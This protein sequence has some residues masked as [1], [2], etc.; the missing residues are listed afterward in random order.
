[1]EQERILSVTPFSSHILGVFDDRV[2]LEECD[3][4]QEGDAIPVV[5]QV[6]KN[7]W[8]E[9][10]DLWL[11][12]KAEYCKQWNEFCGVFGNFYVRKYKEV[13]TI[14][15]RGD[16]NEEKEIYEFI[17]VPLCVA[18]EIDKHCDMEHG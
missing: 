4:Y 1:M 3:Y 15:I 14:N 10:C 12:R 5:I 2:F 16:F 7:L 11:Q 17:D 13:G 18:T 6:E 9:L 8:L